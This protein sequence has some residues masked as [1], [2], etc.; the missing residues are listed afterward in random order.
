MW[1]SKLNRTNLFLVQVGLFISLITFCVNIQETMAQKNGA[2]IELKGKVIDG[3]NNEPLTGVSVYLTNSK[4]G[5]ITDIKGEFRLIAIKDDILKISY[6]GYNDLEIAVTGAT[7]KIKLQ[8]KDISLDEVVVVGYGVMKKS[9]LTGSI[10]Q[11]KNE[12]S[13]EKAYASIQEMMQGQVSGVQIVQNTGALG[14]GMTFN[15]R[16]ANSVTGSNQPLVVIDGYP[17]ES[18]VFGIT[19]GSDASYTGDTPGMNALSSLNPNDVES[20]EILKDASATAIYG[21]RGAN[22]VVMVTTKR[23][24]EGKDRVEYSFRTDMS[25]VPRKIA[26]LSTADYLAYSNEASM[27]KYDGTFSYSNDNIRQYEGIDTNWQDLIFQTGMSQNHQLNISGG[28]KKMKY[29]L[30]LGYLNQNGVVKSTNYERG[31][32]RLNLDREISWRLKFGI[33]I[34]GEMSMNKAVNQSSKFGNVGASVIASAL[35]TQ[36][37]YSAYNPDDDEIA[38]YNSGVTTN[39][40]LLV[41]KAKDQT[42]TNQVNVSG[43]MDF[44]FT[45]YLFLRERLGGKTMNALR[46][47]YM[48]RGTYL[49]DQYQGFA[50]YGNVRNSDYLTETTLNFNR[51]FNKK[52]SVN[53]VGGYTWQSWMAS[54][55]GINT[56]GIPNDD[57]TFYNMG[58]STTVNKPQTTTTQWS[59]ASVLARFNYVYDKK[60][61]LTVTS[62]A[63]G[64]TRLAPGRKWKVF[65]SVALG[66]NVHNERFMKRNELFNELK[67]RASYGVSGNQSI[68]VGSTLSKYN[69]TT[70]VINETVTNVYYPGNMPNPDLGWENT[71]QFNTG[72][73]LTTFSNRL[74]FSFN[75]Y[76]KHT[77]NLLINLPIPPTTGY[78][79]YAS[80][81]GEVE[82]QGFEFDLT[83]RIL[84]KK[85]QWKVNG[86][87]SFNRNKVL[88]FDGTMQSF[89]GP[90]FSVV[91]SQPLHIAQVGYPIGSF[92]GYVIDGIYQTQEEI[93]SSPVDPANPRPGSFKF[94]DI[95][96]P[97]G[98]PDGLISG[99]DRKIIGSPY[100]D[101]IFGVTNDFVWKG[102]S[103]NIFIQGSIGQDVINVNR[104]Y[105]DALTKN[106]SSNVSVEAFQNRWT[107]PGTSNVY[108]VPRAVA[109]PFEGRFTNFIVEDGSF[110]RLKN[111]TFAYTFPQKWIKPLANVKLFVTGNNLVT[112]TKYK[113]YD[114]EVNAQGQNSLTPGVDLGTIPQYR[115]FS[116]GF[117]VN[118]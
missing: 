66:W 81:S 77:S 52:H 23:G 85:L 70:G 2:S 10:S 104:Y 45:K 114:P 41:T 61:L 118:F 31:T 65:P 56:G 59:L 8:P 20:I 113:G 5:T 28:D 100:P 92:Y 76:N 95:S 26:V 15:I 42:R 69:N 62:R 54:T 73:D 7:P 50:Y 79:Q 108:P 78:E 36:P 39:P 46:Q 93:N 91:N 86:N 29:A 88:N 103:L 89:L 12:K 109:L 21:S 102:F 99:F 11:L 110:I 37:I 1:K 17:V 67:L 47:Y 34:N 4:R 94:V 105:L 53:A 33:N 48:P 57:I 90:S 55:D 38:I 106:T 22:G 115:T 112:L 32:I 27:D 13:T 74:V 71:Q 80:N 16:G 63:D 9:D 44:Y 64:S 6:V 14:G 96:G 98:K 3:Q 68:G 97:D 83:T 30:A 72:L 82:N 49:G 116:A 107:G 117:N 58:T 25:Y 111:V 60:Y 51:T 84:T 18:G 19:T 35:R 43:F 24:K 87:L 75:Y 40:L 101:F